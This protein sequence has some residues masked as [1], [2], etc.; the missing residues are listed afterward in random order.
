MANPHRMI[1]LVF[2]TAA[3][4]A[5]QL[6]T[7]R[8]ENENCLA[9]TIILTQ[10]GWLW[11]FPISLSISRARRL[12]QTREDSGKAVPAKAEYKI[13]SHNSAAKNDTYTACVSAIEFAHAQIITRKPPSLA[14]AGVVVCV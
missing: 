9:K 14:R 11:S 3:A 5:Q 12:H 8:R 7:L 6:V 2:V 10:P 13:S 4:A 1:F